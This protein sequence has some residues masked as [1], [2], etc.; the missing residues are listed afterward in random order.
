MFHDYLDKFSSSC[1]NIH[2][3]RYDTPCKGSFPCFCNKIT[4]Y[5]MSVSKNGF[6]LF[7]N[8]TF[9]NNIG[10]SRESYTPI[11][12]VKRLKCYPSVGKLNYNRKTLHAPPKTK[13]LHS[14][15]IQ[16][17]CCDLLFLELSEEFPEPICK[18]SLSE[19]ML[20][21]QY[22]NDE[23]WKLMSVLTHSE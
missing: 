5:K 1:L 20:I 18:L 21:P 9:I 8:Q 3:D 11:G 4:E 15:L 12:I 13:Y 2:S 10:A 7:I 14:T 16:L 17:I 19:D 6:K 23:N 22:M